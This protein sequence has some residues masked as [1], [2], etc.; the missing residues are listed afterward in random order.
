MASPSA[1]KDSGSRIPNFFKMTIRERLEALRERDLLSD[2]DIALLSA[3]DHTL[4]I[5]T[6][7]KM[8][9]NV[10]GVLGLP[11]GLALNF[12]INGRDYVVPLCVEEPSIVAGLSAAART[13]RLPGGFKSARPSNLIG[14]VQLVDMAIRKDRRVEG[15]PRRNRQSCKT[16]CPKMVARGGGDISSSLRRPEDGPSDGGA[17]SAGRYPRRVGDLVNTIARRCI[18][19]RIDHWRQG[20]PADCRISPIAHSR[21][22]NGVRSTISKAKVTAAQVRDGIILITISRRSTRTARRRTTKGSCLAS[23][24]WRTTVTTG[25]PSS[26]S[27]R[28]CGRRVAA[29][30]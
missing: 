10:V 19:R 15:A 7:D 21:G 5:Q 3:G 11:L 6:A 2:D 4:R 29:R 30:R 9:E 28:V 24:R 12:L 20:I 13:A 17:A 1:S 18:A 14:Q 16:A 26:G 23:T 25:A 27:A 22:R 8:I